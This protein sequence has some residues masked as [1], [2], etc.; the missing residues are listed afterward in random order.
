G[1]TR[2]ATHGRPSEE[3]A[4]PHVE[5]G[6]A[7]VHNGIIENY[8]SL[9][10]EL[11]KQGSVFKSETDTEVLAHLIAQQIKTGKGLEDSVTETLKQVKGSYAIVVI[12]KDEPDKII[13]ARMECPLVVGLGE[14]EGFI[15]S[16]IPAILN[17]TRRVIFLDDGEI[18]TVTKHE[19][20]VKTIDGKEIKKTPRE[21][22]WSPVMAE[23]GGYRHFMLK[24]I[25]EQS[26][27]VTDTFRGRISE[28]T[29]NVILDDFKMEE[30]DLKA[31][32]RIYIIACGTS[33]H[34]G[35]V[36][37]FLLEEFCRIPTEVDLGSEF[38]Y[39]NP[40]VDKKTLVIAISQS[41]ET[42]DTFAAIKEAK[43]KGARVISI[44]NVIESSIAR[45]SGN[46][47]YTHAGPEIGVASTK[48]FTTQL[49]ALYLLALHLG[50]KLGNI[51]PDMAKK[52]IHELVKIPKKIDAI[53]MDE[54]KIEAIAK[55]YFHL[56]DFLYLGRGINYP[57]AL[58]G[59]LK[60][61]EISYIHAEGY[62]AGEMKHGP[63]ALIDED[64]PVVALAPKDVL[65]PKI[66][67][68]IEEVKAR[69][70]RIIAVVNENDTEASKKADDVIIIPAACHHL[71][72]ILLTIPLQ[73]LAYHIAV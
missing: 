17:R 19:V 11:K 4:H 24:E 71:T 3:N 41:G 64:M 8:L 54:P 52:L 65:Y 12:S 28:E 49:T 33:W 58:E 30:K 42:L 29:G 51:K 68:N 35:L 23:K 31:V 53:L 39:R 22:D 63:I 55:R 61:K 44:C 60:L 69:G 73:M 56:R 6:V 20:Q 5:S 47:I 43:R 46:V 37:K 38:R 25:F 10:E 40:L 57:V 59:A 14:G 7:V 67:G 1:H 9:K 48:A 32:E 15:A 70:G 2:W 66:L 13:G 16:D 62:P 45:E 27:A 26:R 36:G 50:I 72:P 34:A 21:I 18:V